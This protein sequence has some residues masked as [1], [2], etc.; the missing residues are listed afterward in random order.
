MN[1]QT[2][3]RWQKHT[4]TCNMSHVPCRSN[5]APRWPSLTR[6]PRTPRTPRN[7][8]TSTK[9]TAV[10]GAAKTPWL[11]S[12]IPPPRH[13]GHLIAAKSCTQ[14]KI[15][16]RMFIF[17]HQHRDIRVGFQWFSRCADLWLKILKYEW[18]A[19]RQYF[20][21]SVA[22]QIQFLVFVRMVCA[23]SSYCAYPGPSHIGCYPSQISP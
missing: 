18:G 6:T 8:S 9:T 3:P 22:F 19:G 4:A 23:P 14:L 15:Q 13:V 21:T 16:P 10:D 12:Q 7:Q 11:L 2:H 5:P 20:A 1:K 17:H